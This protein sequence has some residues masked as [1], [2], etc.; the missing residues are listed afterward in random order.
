MAVRVEVKSESGC[1]SEPAKVLV[2]ENDQLVA[3]VIAKVELKQGADDGWY[4]C[5]TLEKKNANTEEVIAE[6]RYCPKCGSRL[7]HLGAHMLDC[8]T[9][10]IWY[11]FY[12]C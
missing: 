4:H 2:Y 8:E 3:E 12:E 1:S 9:A 10:I 6:D 11:D 7:E 5:I